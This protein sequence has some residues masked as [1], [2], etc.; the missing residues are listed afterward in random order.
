MMDIEG[1]LRLFKS[2][3]ALNIRLIYAQYWEYLGAHFDEIL[4]AVRAPVP[5]LLLS[6]SSLSEPGL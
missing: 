1:S 3:K 5:S 6:L 2:F 4:V